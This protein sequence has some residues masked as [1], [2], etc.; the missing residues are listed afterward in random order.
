MAIGIS[1]GM[2]EAMLAGWHGIASSKRTQFQARLRKLQRFDIPEGVGSGRGVAVKYDA[3]QITETALAIEFTQLG[4]TPERLTRVLRQNRMAIGLALRMSAMS[5]LE[6]PDI[7]PWEDRDEKLLHMFIYFDPNAL[8]TLTNQEE[9]D[10]DWAAAS[11]FRSGAA[12]LRENLVPWT[13][14]VSRLSLIN[15]TVMLGALAASF[16]G[17]ERADFLMEVQDWAAFLEYRMDEYSES[18]LAPRERTYLHLRNNVIDAGRNSR[19]FPDEPI[20]ERQ[21]RSELKAILSDP[22]IAPHVE[23][24]HNAEDYGPL[25]LLKL[26]GPHALVIGQFDVPDDRRQFAKYMRADVNQLK[27]VSWPVDKAKNYGVLFVPDEAILEEALKQDGSLWERAFVKGIFLATPSNMVAMVEA[28][29]S[30]WEAGYSVT[31]RASGDSN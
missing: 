13:L 25:T 6:M 29:S 18:E 21:S 10:W 28:S 30:A 23:W 15:T 3:G 24:N 9:E 2:L 4:L 5:L 27:K 11:L 7:V 19:F 31:E 8:R 14:E 22:R 20:V 1:F 17:K 12:D 26:P 16:E